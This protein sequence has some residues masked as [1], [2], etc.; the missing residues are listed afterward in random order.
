[1]VWPLPAGLVWLSSHLVTSVTDSGSVFDS[2][3]I[4][5]M[6]ARR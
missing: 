6:A 1:M 4:S 5:G 2:G 3:R